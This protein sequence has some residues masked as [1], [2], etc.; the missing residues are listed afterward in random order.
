MVLLTRACASLA[1]PKDFFD[2][3]ASLY[4]GCQR[5]L[6]LQMCCLPSMFRGQ[7]AKFKSKRIH[8]VGSPAVS[9]CVLFNE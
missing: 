3:L 8:P 9:S 2:C 4:E 5:A 7:L 1:A 6:F